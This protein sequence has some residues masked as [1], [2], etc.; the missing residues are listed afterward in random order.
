MTPAQRLRRTQRLGANAVAAA[1]RRG[2]LVRSPRLHLYSLP[3]GL[4]YARLGLIVPKRLARRAVDRNRLR[5]LI[6]EAFRLSQT[7]CTGRDIVFRLVKP[8][9]SDAISLADVQALV[10]R[11][12]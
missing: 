1:L 3:N 4:A 12:R 2:Q 7:A 8:Q 5:R 10:A 9:G 11:D 6:R